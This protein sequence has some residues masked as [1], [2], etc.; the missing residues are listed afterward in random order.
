MIWLTVLLEHMRLLQGLKTGDEAWPASWR[1]HSVLVLVLV[2][3]F[4]IGAAL[5]QLLWHGSLEVSLLGPR[6]PGKGSAEAD[7]APDTMLHRVRAVQMAEV[8]RGKASADEADVL[9]LHPLIPNHRADLRAHQVALQRTVR[10]EAA[11]LGQAIAS[12]QQAEIEGMRTML[13]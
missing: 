5:A 9:F 6:T 12:L 2:V 7:F 8:V 3:L 13:Q 4:I 10:P 11:L 1:S